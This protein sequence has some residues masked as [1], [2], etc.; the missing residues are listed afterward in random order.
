LFLCCW[1]KKSKSHLV[2]FI[3]HMAAG[4]AYDV[5]IIRSGSSTAG[6]FSCF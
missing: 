1:Y 2:Y 3:S 4:Y 5:T 6:S